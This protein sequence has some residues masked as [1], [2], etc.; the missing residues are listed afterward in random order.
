M[1]RGRS[2]AGACLLA[3]LGAVVC[4]GVGGA[5]D[6]DPSKGE[7]YTNDEIMKLSG[8]DR[9]DYCEKMEQTLQGYNDEAALYQARLDSMQVMADTLRAQTLALSDSIRQVNN[10]LRELRL[11]RKTLETYT[12]KGGETIAHLAKMILGDAN[13]ATELVQG[14]KQALSGKG[15]DDPLPAGIKIRIPR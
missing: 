9:D 1:R 6:K 7:Y 12:T 11:K 14:N 15:Q 10:E 13:R 8:S 3:V 2:W 4:A 5:L